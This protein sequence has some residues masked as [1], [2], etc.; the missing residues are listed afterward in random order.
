V[1]AVGDKGTIL[2]SEDGKSWSA[3]DSKTAATLNAA[4]AAG[5][6][7]LWAVGARGATVGS[8]DGGRTWTP[9]SPVTGRDLISIDLTGPSH[10][11]AVGA[12]GS[13]QRLEP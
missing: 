4:A 10:G 2:R 12:R 3:A 5:D 1:I 7:V 13:A 6:N 11:V 8:A 9:I